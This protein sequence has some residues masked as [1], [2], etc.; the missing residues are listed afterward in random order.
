MASSGEVFIVPLTRL[1]A[2]SQAQAK[3]AK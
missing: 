2:E 3:A 1:S